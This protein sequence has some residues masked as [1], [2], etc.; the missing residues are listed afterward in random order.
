[1]CTVT[2]FHVP[3]RCPFSTA[4]IQEGHPVKT[5]WKEI[6][7]NQHCQTKTIRH[8]LRCCRT[9]PSSTLNTMT[10]ATSTCQRSK[11][12]KPMS[13]NFKTLTKFPAS[14]HFLRHKFHFLPLLIRAAV[15]EMLPDK[16][17]EHMTLLSARW[18]QWKDH[19]DKKQQKGYCAVTW[20]SSAMDGQN[21]DPVWL[22]WS[23][24]INF[25]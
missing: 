5:S 6:H 2:T 21:S 23:R 16:D 25:R 20:Y 7:Y 17:V 11:G 3:T 13:Q 15:K 19:C 4:Q 24:T 18:W 1:M 22:S 12:S 10:P 9:V 14:F 8:V